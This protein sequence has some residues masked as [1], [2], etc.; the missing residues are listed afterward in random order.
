MTDV[1]FS[2]LR[3][4]AAGQ[5]GLLGGIWVYSSKKPQ[6]ITLNIPWESSMILKTTSRQKVAPHF[7]EKELR[8]IKAKAIRATS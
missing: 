6:L 1:G 3:R 8:C 5:P 7:T 2:G 4:A